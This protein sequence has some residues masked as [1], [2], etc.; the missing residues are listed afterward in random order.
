MAVATDD[1]LTVAGW[2]CLTVPDVVSTAAESLAL[3][4]FGCSSTENGGFWDPTVYTKWKAG[5]C[6]GLSNL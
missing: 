3:E 4:S 5:P 2:C 1:G 6:I